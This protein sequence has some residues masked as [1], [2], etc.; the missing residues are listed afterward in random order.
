MHSIVIKLTVETGEDCHKI[1]P[2]CTF[3][4]EVISTVPIVG[5]TTIKLRDR[6]MM[7]P[8]DREKRR[9]VASRVNRE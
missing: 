9:V 5:T 4:M 7:C 8:N 1:Y 6:S 2:F 3:C